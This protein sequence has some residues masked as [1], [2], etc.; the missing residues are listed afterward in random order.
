LLIDLPCHL[1]SSPCHAK[2]NPHAAT[3]PHGTSHHIIYI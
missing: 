3:V 1:S 2:P